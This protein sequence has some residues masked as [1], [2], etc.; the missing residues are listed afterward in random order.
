M[1]QSHPPD[2]TVLFLQVNSA[3]FSVNN[4][5]ELQTEEA[6]HLACFI[7][8]L[9]IHYRWTSEHDH[10]EES[11][12]AYT[13]KKHKIINNVTILFFFV[14]CCNLLSLFDYGDF[15]RLGHQR[16]SQVDLRK[17]FL[18]AGSETHS[19]CTCV[20]EVLERKRIVTYLHGPVKSCWS[21]HGYLGFQQLIK[22]C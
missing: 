12:V 11:H 4:D 17:M 21:L 2:V 16:W 1:H 6:W 7:K 19:T 14:S 22:K 5:L 3:S 18:P 13:F 20:S 8:D 9:V 15:Q 10:W